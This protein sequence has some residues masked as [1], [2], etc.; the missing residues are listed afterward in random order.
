MSACSPDKD[1]RV[2]IVPKRTQ[3]LAN[4]AV[5]GLVPMNDFAIDEREAAGEIRR[6]V[7]GSDG[8]HGG[9]NDGH[10]GSN[11]GQGGSR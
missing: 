9:S 1:A 11:G 3:L 7:G 5:A 8:S 10:G 6:L 4:P 2:A